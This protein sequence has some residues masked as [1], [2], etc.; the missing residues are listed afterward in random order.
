[1]SMSPTGLIVTKDLEVNMRSSIAR[2]A[3]D[4]VKGNGMKTTPPLSVR[5]LRQMLAC[6]FCD[7]VER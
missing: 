5:S 3:E 7:P 6:L 4:C 2:F 1:M